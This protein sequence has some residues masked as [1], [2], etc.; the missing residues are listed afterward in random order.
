[1]VKKIDGVLERVRDPE[2]NL[3]VAELGLVERCRYSPSR[4]RLDVWL[5]P[6]RPGPV[7]CSMVAGLLLA[8]TIKALV[9][10]L[11]KEFPSLSVDVVR[12]TPR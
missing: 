1:M 10:G 8:D 11:R 4:Q 12:G 9:D 3:S 5:N 7:C 6:V 2:T